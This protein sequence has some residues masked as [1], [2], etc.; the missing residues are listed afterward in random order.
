VAKTKEP[1]ISQNPYKGA[2]KRAAS[3]GSG[4][5]PEK[6]PREAPNTAG[7]N[8]W[9]VRVRMHRA[10]E[11]G[12][13]SL[14]D[15]SRE[16]RSELLALIRRIEDLPAASVFSSAQNCKAYSDMS[17]CPNSETTKRLAE[18]YQGLDSL[19]RFRLDGTTRVYGARERNE[20]HFLWWDRDHEVWPSEKKH[21]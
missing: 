19:V 11:G 4:N 1:K 15:M 14:L 21:T 9:H 13:W 3:A 6:T 20:F 8:T 5:G 7:D 17:D 10:D 12:T 18:E 2:G 16:E